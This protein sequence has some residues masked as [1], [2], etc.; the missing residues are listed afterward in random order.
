MFA[1]F[2]YIT[3]KYV[4][5]FKPHPKGL[6]IPAVGQVVNFALIWS[7]IFQTVSRSQSTLII[8]EHNN[9]K[10]NAA[11]LHAVTAAGQLGGE[12]G[13]SDNFWTFL[14]PCHPQV[15]CLVAGTGC[16]AVAK[17]VASVAGVSKVG[18]EATLKSFK[19][20][21]SAGLACRLSRLHW[22]P[23]RA[24]H[25][26][27]RLRP[28]PVQIHTYRSGEWKSHLF[29]YMYMYDFAYFFSTCHTA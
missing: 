12:V 18:V 25:P 19:R 11:T 13:G 3:A 7:N 26:P 16:A 29:T 2:F 1:D 22:L 10:L 28:E 8:A 17:E 20:S 5:H 6:L 9:E 21:Q 14:S 24:P 15:N 27:S 23:A 4:E